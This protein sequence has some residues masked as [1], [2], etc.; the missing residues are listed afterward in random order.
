MP[1]SWKVGQDGQIWATWPF[2][3]SGGFC[4]GAADASNVNVDTGEKNTANPAPVPCGQNQCPGTVNGATICVPCRGQQEQGPTTA[5][6]APAGAASAGTG[7]SSTA[8]ECNGITCTTTTTTRDGSGNITGTAATTD[9][10]ENFC[11]ANPQSSL[12][13]QS[14]FGGSCAATTCEGDA[15]AC[16]IAADQYRRNCQ[17]FDD[18]ETTPLKQAGDAAMTGQLLPDGHPLKDAATMPMDFGSRI[19]QMDR[20]GGGCPQDVTFTLSGTTVVMPFSKA[21]APLHLLGQIAMAITMLAC[22]FIVFKT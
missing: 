17:W 3:S 18:P 21:C 10:Q 15:V 13:K 9:K 20:L 7:S 16:A 11:K 14:S 12:C 19:D 6:S 4:K 8:T 5:A 2:K 1:S 22:C